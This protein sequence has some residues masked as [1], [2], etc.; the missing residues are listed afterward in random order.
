MFRKA[1][2]DGTALSPPNAIQEKAA[3]QLE[4]DRNYLQEAIGVGGQRLQRSLSLVQLEPGPARDVPD[5]DPPAAPVHRLH[6][7]LPHVGRQ[8]VALDGAPGPDARGGRVEG[9]PHHGGGRRGPGFPG[10]ERDPGETRG[11]RRRR[12]R[13]RP[14]PGEEAARSGGR[15][16]GEGEGEGGGV[17]ARAGG[18]RKGEAGGDGAHR[19]H[20]CGG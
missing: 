1:F 6:R 13:P 8:P 5:R 19:F 2:T 12:P 14:P 18:G 4:H 7:P 15:P 11:R 3:W 10:P 17:E 16:E 20:C 9:G